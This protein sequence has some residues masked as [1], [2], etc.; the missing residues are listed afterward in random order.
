MPEFFR[1]ARCAG[2]GLQPLWTRHSA[3]SCFNPNHGKRRGPMGRLEDNI[4][5]ADFETFVLIF[6]DDYRKI[7][8]EL[9]QDIMADVGEQTLGGL[10]SLFIGGVVISGVLALTII[11]M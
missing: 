8:E 10:S 11:P 5:R 6:P 1:F 2:E 3:V 7:L 4:L 9:R